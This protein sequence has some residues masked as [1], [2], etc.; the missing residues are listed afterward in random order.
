VLNVLCVAKGMV[1]DT[2]AYAPSTVDSVDCLIRCDSKVDSIE[3]DFVIH[4]VSFT[5]WRTPVSSG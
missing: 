5:Y 1:R 3:S 2:N 4:S